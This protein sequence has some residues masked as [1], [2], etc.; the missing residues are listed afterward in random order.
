[1]AGTTQRIV[2]GKPETVI[3]VERMRRSDE[4]TIERFTP[5]AEL[6]YRAAK[7]VYDAVNWHGSIAVVAG[8]GNNGGDG[9]ALACI[10]A[11]HGIRP[12]VF[13]TSDKLTDT[14][15]LYFE[16]AVNEGLCVVPFTEDTSFEAFDILVDCILGTGFTG[17]VRGAARAA[18]QAVNAANAYVV[19]VD[20]N[21][22]LNGDTGEAALA[23]KSDLTVSIGYY[24]QGMFT[25][26]AARYIGSMVNVDIGIVLV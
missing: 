12:K 3:S 22:G 15:R 23:V 17:M 21:S 13:R 6:M 2:N 19:S 24:K 1:M 26:D 8:G 20:I 25:G 16:K 10:L 5:G 18:I 4:Y 7:G 14:G 9:F 11:D